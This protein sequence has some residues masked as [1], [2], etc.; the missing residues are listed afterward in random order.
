[1]VL[2]NPNY[3]HGFPRREG[4]FFQQDEGSN[5]S[6]CMPAA[7]I[8]KFDDHAEIHLF[9]PGRT[10]QDFSIKLDNDVLT[11]SSD[12]QLDEQGEFIQQEFMLGEFSRNFQISDMIDNEKIE[13]NYESGILK[14]KLPFKEETQPKKRD[15]EIS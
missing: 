15:I 14:I 9:A 10:K 1:M 3:R 2:I 8:L 4:P 11:I 12:S 6:G 7:N 5:E 13:A